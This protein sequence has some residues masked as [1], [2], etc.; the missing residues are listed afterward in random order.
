MNRLP[1]Q[2]HRVA[3]TCVAFIATTAFIADRTMA[4]PPPEKGDGPLAGPRHR[5]G[6]PPGDAAGGDMVRPGEEGPPP[7]ESG[8][9]RGAKGWRDRGDRWPR[10]MEGDGPLN[11]Q[12]V[13]RV[14]A[15]LKERL[16]Q[17]HDRLIALK[18]NDPQK[19]DMAMRRLLPMFR[20]A[21]VLNERNPKLAQSMFEEFEL[22]HELRGL[23]E[24]YKAASGANDQP[25]M[26]QIVSEI[27]GRVR[28]QF[29]LRQERRQAQLEE[30]AKR[31]AE[32]Q[33]RIEK[34]LAEHAEQSE[35]SEEFIAR[36]IEEIKKGEFRGPSLFGGPGRPG[37]PGGPDGEFG[38]RGPRRRGMRPPPGA[39]PM[40]DRGPGPGEPRPE[41][42]PPPHPDDLEGP[43]PGGPPM[44]HGDEPDMPP[45]P[46]ED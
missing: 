11:E 19:F 14:L 30:F 45:P 12:M 5:P 9:P 37:R 20:D 46:P 28:K 6:P 18:A 17:W 41:G 25:Q 8:G 13:E 15:E 2:I 27:D 23:A 26:A 42:P 4:K 1:N 34:E 7:G 33:K 39:G 32:Q 29:A 22:E 38:P 44:G 36:R 21:M 10:R 40:N 35:K 31:L 16:P 3:L 24:K 43:P